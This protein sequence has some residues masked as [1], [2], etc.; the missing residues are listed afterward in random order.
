MLN[1]ADKKTIGDLYDANVSCSRCAFQN[2]CETLATYL[3]EL[4]KNPNCAQLVNI[5]LGD[6]KLTDV[7]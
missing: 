3:E 2:K 1:A 6:S 7:E 4:G 5:L